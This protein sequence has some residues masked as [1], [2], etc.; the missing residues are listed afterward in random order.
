MGSH[1]G[2][3]RFRLVVAIAPAEVLLGRRWS[4]DGTAS[5]DPVGEP[6]GGSALVPPIRSVDAGSRGAEVMSARTTIRVLGPVDIRTPT[7]VRAIGG[8]HVRA[9]LA[10]LVVGAGHAVPIDH[11]ISVIWR[12]DPPAT[13]TNTL[14]SYVSQLRRLLGSDS[15]AS[16]D[17]SYVLVLDRLDIDAQL[18][19]A[20]LRRAEERRDDHEECLAAVRSALSRWRGRPFG[21]LADDEPFALESYRLDELR[22]NAVELGLEAELALGRHELVIGELEATIREH[23]YREHLWR[24]LVDALVRGERR[25][26]ALRACAQLRHTL[27]EVGVTAGPWVLELEREILGAAPQED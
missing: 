4:L 3:L 2:R 14:Q 18:F 12:D 5:D 24:L 10:A 25:V 16:I 23:P 19:E 13:A 6:G 26:E 22:L 9:L 21:D 20:D 17:H 15:I 11:L 1:W 7:R 8:H 27:G